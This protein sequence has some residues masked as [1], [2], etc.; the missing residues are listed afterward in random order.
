[1]FDVRA[2]LRWHGS[3]FQSGFHLE[4]PSKAFGISA[5]RAACWRVFYLRWDVPDDGQAL[6]QETLDNAPMAIFI[7]CHTSD[8]RQ[9][10]EYIGLAF[11]R[12]AL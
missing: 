5:M 10:A 1:L 8:I 4:N 2:L 6:V 7:V 3:L 11:H 12:S 9:S